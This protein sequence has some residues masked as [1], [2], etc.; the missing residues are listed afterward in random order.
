MTQRTRTF[1]CTFHST[2]ALHWNCL[3]CTTFPAHD[4]YL[5]MTTQQRGMTHVWKLYGDTKLA[6]SFNNIISYIP[7]RISISRTGHICIY[8]SS[9]PPC[10]HSVTLTSICSLQNLVK[11][12]MSYVQKGSRWKKRNVYSQL[13][14]KLVSQSY[15]P[16]FFALSAEQQLN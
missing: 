3:K 5:K 8:R 12:K 2:G 13:Q 7:S 10:P 4:K 14:L 9:T 11:I 6:V 16:P 15:N 1:K